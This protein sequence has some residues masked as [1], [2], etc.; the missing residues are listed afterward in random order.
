MVGKD[1][2]TRILER[3][4]EAAS[5]RQRILAHNVANVAT[6]G[7]KRSRVEFED[8][9]AVALAEGQDPDA[10]VPRVEVDKDSEGRPDGNNVDI[11]LEMTRMA[12]NQIFYAALTRELSNQFERLRMAINDGRR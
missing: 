10:V 2:A 9:L 7:F 5:L 4:L 12:E 8:Q 3:G 11:E 1:L 6:P